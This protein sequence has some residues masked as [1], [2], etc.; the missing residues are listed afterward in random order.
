MKNLLK[1]EIEKLVPGGDG[2]TRYNGFVIFVPYGVPGDILKVKV[3]KKRDYG[4]G[5]IVEILEPSEH[6]KSPECPLFPKCGGCQWQM[7]S[8]DSQV[9][10]KKILIEEAFMRVAKL[11][12]VPIEKT[13]KMENP[14]RFRNKVQYPVKRVRERKVVMGFYEKG[15]H[16]IVD[17]EECPV[18]LKQFDPVM[19]PFKELLRREPITIYDEERHRGKLRHFILRGSSKTKE[20][21]VILVMRLPGLSKGLA[22]KIQELDR[23]RIIGVV[24]NINPEI[25]NVI[26]GD[27][28][29]KVLGRDYYFEKIGG[30]TFK[31]SST[32][33]FQANSPMAERLI[34]FMK[35]G[36]G[37]S[38][39]IIDAY[40]GV[41]LFSLSLAS[42]A[43]KVI[44]IEESP[45]S[46]YDSIDNAEI[47][48]LGNVEFIHG[49]VQDFLDTFESPDFLIV[50]P[51]RRGLEKETIE[52][53]H[54]LKPPK[55]FYVSC[56]PVTL[57]R[58]IR[59]LMEGGYE[60]IYVKPFDFFPH[61]HHIE[62][63]SYLERKKI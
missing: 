51:P 45:S 21:L 63:L 44:G 36:I 41:G 28:S 23:E 31:V 10:F 22:E 47:N 60:L 55:I 4:I 14:W 56:N 42:L 9:K 16:H 57:A 27:E 49:K 7:I 52:A 13:V 35:E 37:Y 20:T 38:K 26:M 54:K 2:L 33:F 1:V 39:L 59:D 11:R 12:E 43:E 58:D 17:M 3:K 53:I 50:D 5:E 62:T 25:T 18:Q 15:T 6:R 61:T 19:G 40:S 48:L 8:Y 24:E 29:R 46:H 30:L 34:N 32:S